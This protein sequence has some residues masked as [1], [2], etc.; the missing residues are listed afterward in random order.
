MTQAGR[1]LASYR[2]IVVALEA[3][4]PIACIIVEG[5]ATEP[6]RSSAQILAFAHRM[7][8][9]AAA[10]VEWLFRRLHL[11][12]R[13]AAGSQKSAPDVAPAASTGCSPRSP[14]PPS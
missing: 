10:A 5:A 6:D 4:N 14:R 1:I 11:T 2:K 13:A 8:A 9:A 3:R 7:P 12:A